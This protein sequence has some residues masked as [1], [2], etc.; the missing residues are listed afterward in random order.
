MKPVRHIIDSSFKWLSLSLGLFWTLQ[1]FTD[2]ILAQNPF[3][4]TYVI[5]LTYIRADIGAHSATIPLLFAL[6]VYSYWHLNTLHGVLR[7]AVSVTFVMLG[8]NYNAFFWSLG[9]EL[10]NGTGAPLVNLSFFI[11]TMLLLVIVNIRY[12]VLKARVARVAVLMTVAIGVWLMF[13]DSGFYEAWYLHSKVGG[14]PDPHGWLWLLR[15]V[16]GLAVPTAL[17]ADRRT[18]TSVTIE[19]N[20]T[21]K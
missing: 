7:T 10:K 12:T 6:Y 17:I 5:P 16:T 4:I 9:D 18:F 8:I 15:G 21:E 14:Y 11:M 19:L 3:T 1:A 20:K 2:M 13:Y